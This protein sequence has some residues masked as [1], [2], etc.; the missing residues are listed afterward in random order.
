MKTKILLAVFSAVC[1]VRLFA[2]DPAVSADDAAKTLARIEAGL[3]N[4]KSLRADFVQT[5]KISLFDKEMVLRGNVEIRYPDGFKWTVLSPVKTVVEMDA[6]KARIWDEAT[7]ETRTFSRGDNPMMDMMWRQLGAWFMGRYDELSKDYAISV[8]D[9]NETAPKLLFKPKNKLIAK[10]VASVELSF[11]EKD[12]IF[13][14][15]KVVMRE[16][17]GDS[18]TV[19]FENVVVSAKKSPAAK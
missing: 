10:V 1:A 14:L 13:F 15:S 19:E 7:G 5:N 8:V 11:A 17:S 18:T 16:K 4:T 9:A 6:D 3:R 2:A 12:G